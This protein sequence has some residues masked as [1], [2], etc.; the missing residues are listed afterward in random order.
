MTRMIRPAS[1]WTVRAFSLTLLACLFAASSPAPMRDLVDDRV[2]VHTPDGAT[3]SA[4]VVRPA[5]VTRAPAA[6][7]FTIYADP[8]N[9]IRRMRYA[10]S[11][12]YVAVTAYTRGKGY[13]P[14]RIVPYEYDGRDANAVIGWIAKQ[15]WS[16]G[17]VGMYGGSYNGF[18]QWAAAKWHNP[19]LKTIVPYVANNPGD[20]LPMQANVF[21]LVNYAWIDY[22]THDR[23]VYDAA[24][25]NPIWRTLNARWYASGRAYR[26]VDA[27]AGVPN[28]WLHKWL[29]HPSY[30]AYWQ[31]MVPYRGDFAKID[32]PVLTVTGYYD[33]GQISA[34]GFFK[35]HHAYDPT[36]R[37]Y[38]VIGPWDHFGTQHAVKDTVLRG[39]RIDSAAQIDTPK[40]TFDWFDYVMRGAPKPS[41]VAGTVNYEVMGANAWR[42][43]ASLDAMGSPQRF[44]LSTTKNDA[45]SYLLSPSAPAA[46]ESL[47]QSVDFADRKTSNNDSYPYPIVGK[48]PNLS[49]GYCFESRPFE[50]TT[51][52]SGFGGVI[53]TV[54]DKRDM[55]V[56]LVL[57]E[58]LPA[59]ASYAADA[60]K[61]TLLVPDR[62]ATIPIRQAS[63][64]S[65]R[66]VKGSRLL[67]TVNV[68]KNPYAEINYG[69]GKD[70]AAEDIRDAKTP[71]HV[72][73]LTDS[74]IEVE[75]STP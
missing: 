38:L 18:T 31:A 24:Y 57:Y 20:G 32:I 41:L 5:G 51:D 16:D 35:D 74:Y 50:R 72:K 34:L 1:S 2:L 14:D 21:L 25:D 6:L 68:N 12:G 63:L 55:D 73:W 8:A 26:D 39:Y 46:I 56:G 45:K 10:A 33:D 59:R 53:H 60:A 66:M 17:Q 3:I 11:R 58:V 42:H 15:P 54:I 67:L 4:I 61:R 37:E 70:V 43:V 62:P 49:N 30:D 44:Y 36:A 9:D 23:F 19:A 29:R 52:V 13:S 71:L 28:P 40:L 27:I 7:E 75:T 22:V 65:R 47:P 48:T 64:F 69:T